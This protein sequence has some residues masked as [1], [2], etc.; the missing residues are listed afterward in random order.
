VLGKFSPEQKPA[1]ERA[2]EQA[3]DAAE[4]WAS[5][6]LDAAMNKFNTRRSERAGAASSTDAETSDTER[7]D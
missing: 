3:A 1:I 6:G 4:T 5:E 2:I 7:S